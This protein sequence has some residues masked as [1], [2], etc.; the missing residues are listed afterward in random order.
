MRKKILHISIIFLLIFSSF[1]NFFCIYDDV[2]AKL[3]Y[4]SY[5]S[6][7]EKFGNITILYQNGSFYN[8]GYQHGYLLKHQIEENYRAFLSLINDEQYNFILS[9]Y[10]DFICNYIPEIYIWEL[11]GL[12]DGANIS[13]D[14]VVVVNFGWYT[15]IDLACAD[16]SVWDR[17]SKDGQLYHIR[18]WDISYNI[19]DPVTGSYLVENQILIVRKPS[20]GY[21]SLQVSLAGFIE[22]IG[23]FNEAGIAVSYDMSKSID[24]DVRLNPWYIRQKEVLDFAS[25]INQSIKILSINRTGGYNFIISDSKAPEAYVSEFTSKLSYIGTWDDPVESNYPFW[26]I[27]DVIRRKNLFID[28]NTALTQRFP[29]NPRSIIHILNVNSYHFLNWKT[30]KSLSV[31]IEDLWGNL[32]LFNLMDI[33]RDVYCGKTDFVLFLFVNFFDGLGS[34]HQWVACPSSGD[35]IISF[36]DRYNKAQFC[37]PYVFNL[38]DLLD[39]F[40]SIN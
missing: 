10:N 6:R 13:F 4:N 30:Y 14:D 26:S 11:K 3:D 40:I 15:I 28:K 35:M 18:S 12:S 23:G 27:E 20:D 1:I 22:A 29:Y 7:I 31:K 21:V 8:M 9:R 2:E 16:I 19:F 38:Y 32:D 36:G 39:S 24:M 5:N 17:A 37:K 25:T 34:Y 33:L